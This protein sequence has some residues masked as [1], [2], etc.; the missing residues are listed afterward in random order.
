M[1]FQ[2]FKNLY[3]KIEVQVVNNKLPPPFLSVLVQTYQ[4]EKY[5]RECLDGI[6]AQR[7]NFEFEILIGEDN[8]QDK[9]REICL[10][11]AHKFPHKIKLFLHHRENQIK[12][13]GEPTSN[14]NA[15]YNFFSAKGKYI[16][17]CEGDDLWTD[18][19]QLQKQVDYLETNLETVFTYHSFQAIDGEGEVLTDNVDNLQPKIDLSTGDLMKVKYHPLLLCTC[20]RNILNEIP[21]EMMRVINVDT[22]LFSLLGKW[23]EAKFL[24]NVQ[25][26]KYRRHPGGIWSR[27]RKQKKFLSKIITYKNLSIF[28]R[29]EKNKELFKYFHKK[30]K[31]SFKMLIFSMLKEGNLFPAFKQTIRYLEGNLKK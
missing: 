18:P 5:I 27:R 14:F 17:F 28:Y 11:Y 31:E 13:L 21:Y 24:E 9:T 25:P 8:S 16:A 23:G 20:F 6:L 15:F 3:Q 29:R 30:Q 1:N 12:I 2:E 19:F 26:A 22:F 10:E 7:T 4:H